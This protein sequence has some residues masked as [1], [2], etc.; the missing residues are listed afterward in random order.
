MPTSTFDIRKGQDCE[1]LTVHWAEGRRVYKGTYRES[2][3]EYESDHVTQ[4]YNG[5]G[6]DVTDWACAKYGEKELID[7]KGIDE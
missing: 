5:Q 2:Q 3:D 4:V 7:G 1:T 6:E